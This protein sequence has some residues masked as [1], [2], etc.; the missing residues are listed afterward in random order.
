LLPISVWCPE[1][2]AFERTL[3]NSQAKASITS[4]EARSQIQMKR[5]YSDPKYTLTPN[6]EFVQID[7][8]VVIAPFAYKPGPEE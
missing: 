4:G 7:Q 2:T 5:F 1:T 6:S 3:V 8:C